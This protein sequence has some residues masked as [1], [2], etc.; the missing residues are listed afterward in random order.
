MS[1]HVSDMEELFFRALF[2]IAEVSSSDEYVSLLHEIYIKP[3][4]V[5]NELLLE[6]ENCT[7]DP[8]ETRRMFIWEMSN[9]EKYSDEAIVEGYMKA[10]GDLF[11]RTHS[12]MDSL[13]AYD[14]TSQIL[15]LLP[16]DIRYNGRMTKLDR[17]SDFCDFTIMTEEAV[18]KDFIDAVYPDLDEDKKATLIEQALADDHIAILKRKEDKERC[19]YN[20]VSGKRDSLKDKLAFWRR[21]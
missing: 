19:L 21:K 4:N 3:E 1:N 6:L 8:N 17:A 10:L 12:V 11:A 2:W 15:D 9:V 13:A 18:Y 20:D 16:Q 14:V 5:D 7:R